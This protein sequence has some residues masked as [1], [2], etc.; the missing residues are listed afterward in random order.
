MSESTPAQPPESSLQP[1]SLPPAGPLPE[2]L[3]DN[4]GPDHRS[5]FIAVVGRPNAGKSTLLNH[6]L[7]QKI[8]I[9]SP[10]P[11]TTRDQLLGILTT[12]DA[13]YLFLDTPGI[14]KPL[15][16][17]G[18]YMVTVAAETIEDADITLWLVDINVP[19]TEEDAAIADL[20]LRLQHKHKLRTLVLGFNHADRWSAPE[21]DTSVR[22]NQY[23]SL[24]SPL[25]G[26]ALLPADEGRVDHT[27]KQA[28]AAIP[29]PLLNTA[30]FSAASG[31]GLPALQELLRSLLPLGPRYY[32]ED[33][34]T[35]L[36]LRF[37]AAELI[38]E[39]ALLLLQD[40]VPH[41][42]AVEVDDFIER[43]PNLT[44]I[45]AVIYL[46]RESQ[47]PIVLGRDG[48]MIK[49]IGQASRPEIEELV[50]TKVYLE[51]W[52]KVWERWRRRDNLLR[53]LGYATERKKAT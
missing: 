9:T 50:G 29:L 21:A 7:G 39:K 38:R 8:A 34:V 33:Q 32:P 46:E 25:V 23:I 41:S 20:L 16:K 36:Q 2:G 1:G 13:Q 37:I 43:S 10:K 6:L 15:N 5:G 44:Y 31:V 18:E 3:Q 28:K 22:I 26:L 35:D 19:P 48:A 45:S 24:V 52:V 27:A 40:E 11:Q 30:I 47:K 53:Q 51:L 17:L 14:H 49:R 4:L 12:G 42:M